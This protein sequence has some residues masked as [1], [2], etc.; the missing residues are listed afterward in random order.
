MPISTKN[1][2]IS[3]KPVVMAG[4]TAMPTLT[5]TE[6]LNKLNPSLKK[7]VKN[8]YKDYQENAWKFKKKSSPLNQ[9]IKKTHN[10]SEQVFHY[11]EDH[12]T[13]RDTWELAYG[14]VTYSTKWKIDINWLISI[15]T[16]ESGFV[17][18]IGDRYNIYTHKKNPPEKYS[19]GIGQVGIDSAK[20]I[21]NAHG[22]DSKGITIDDLMYFRLL[23]MDISACILAYKIR[24]LGI[25][26]G[27]MAYNC[28]DNGVD[29]GRG[30]KYWHSIKA[31]HKTGG[32]K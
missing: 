1:P 20:S 14:G 32:W 3:V 4:P 23:N 27:I 18:I 17:N 5:F 10:H 9:Y 30:N 28:G 31:I 13:T 24:Q 6:H 11:Y 22:I 7:Y 16:N 12:L 25:P 19:V 21:L 29:L 26:K 2:T 15:W 8:L